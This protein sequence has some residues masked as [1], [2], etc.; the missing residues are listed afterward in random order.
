LDGVR[1]LSFVFWEKLVQQVRGV[2]L[3][4]TLR[5]VEVENGLWDT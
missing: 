3:G 2:S 4:V 5:S 1:L